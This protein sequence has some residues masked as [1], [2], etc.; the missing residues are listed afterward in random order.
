MKLPC[1]KLAFQTT[2]QDVFNIYRIGSDFFFLKKDQRNYFFKAL[3]WHSVL[4]ERKE[5]ISSNLA[6]HLLRVLNHLS[7]EIS[8]K[9]QE[10]KQ[11]D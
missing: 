5:A 9:C 8:F 11:N 1:K 7:P 4:T 6:R 10:A 3:G 2:S